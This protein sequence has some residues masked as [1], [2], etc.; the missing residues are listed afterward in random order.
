[1]R[2]DLSTLPVCWPW[3]FMRWSPEKLTD[4][5]KVTQLDWPHAAFSTARIQRWF[6]DKLVSVFKKYIFFLSLKKKIN[7]RKLM[8]YHSSQWPHLLWLFLIWWELSGLDK[9]PSTMLER[10]PGLFKIQ[11]LLALLPLALTEPWLRG[12]WKQPGLG[13]GSRRVPGWQWTALGTQ[14]S[15]SCSGLED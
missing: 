13:I 11:L 15:W 12:I 8:A 7:F 14:E 2:K 1:M 9:G 3:V 4:M 10:K 6:L 5:L